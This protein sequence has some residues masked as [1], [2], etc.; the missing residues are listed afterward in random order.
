MINLKMSKQDSELLVNAL[1]KYTSDYR[2]LKYGGNYN[3]YQ[4]G[5]SD[6]EWIRLTELL[7]TLNDNNKK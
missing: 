2:P 7:N 5:I 1:T 4:S 3:A 6:D